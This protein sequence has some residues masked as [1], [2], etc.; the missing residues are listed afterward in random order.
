MAY[1]LSKGR[2]RMTDE[3][4]DILYQYLKKKRRGKRFAI[5]EAYECSP[6]S[7]R[8]LFV[9]QA[10]DA[11]HRLAGAGRA[12]RLPDLSVEFRGQPRRE[13]WELL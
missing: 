4:V 1:E 5:M 3:E 11:M 9:D 13:G 10:R 7:A 12:R 6:S 2:R 8:C